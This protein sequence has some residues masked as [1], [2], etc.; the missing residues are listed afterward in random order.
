VE[1]SIDERTIDWSGVIAA[2][3]HLE[4][5][6]RYE[7]TSPISD[8]HNRLM[9]AP[10]R[11]HLDQQRTA[12]RLWTP[13][14]GPIAL[15]RDEFGNDVADV[16]VARV[17]REIV[18]SLEASIVRD[19]RF[20]WNGPTPGDALDRRWTNANRLTRPNDAIR[21]AAERLRARYPD[22]RE[23][24]LAVAQFVSQH[25]TYTKGVTDVFTTAATAYAQGR[26]VCQD[27]AHI[28]ISIARAAGLSARYVSGHLL[29][30]GATH[31]WIEI[32]VNG[33]TSG[34]S[35]LSLDPT[36]D[37]A[38]NFRYVAVAI[39][40]DYDDIPP[41]SGYFSGRGSGTLHGTQNVRLVDVTYAA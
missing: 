10:R 17:E 37:T 7:Y 21:S 38:T 9:I 25:M 32:L 6:L 19:R 39:G 40:R 3:Y 5:S 4:Q 23:R 15:D 26:G 8:L 16:N 31:A 34:P 22:Q 35:V 41:T 27:Y 1:R 29:G 18:F 11:R 2:R 24:A 36:Y 33:R 14:I 12:N 20:A 28:A 13:S 30:E